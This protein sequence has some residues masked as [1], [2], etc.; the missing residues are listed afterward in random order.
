MIVDGAVQ[1]SG[2][3]RGT[4]LHEMELAGM[5]PA[6]F[7]L[8][9]GAAVRGSTVDVTIQ[10]TPVGERRADKDWRLVAALAARNARTVVARGENAGQ[11]LDA[12][13]VVRALSDR[14]AVP[15]PGSSTRI[16]LSKPA[17]LA[18]PD[19][20]L[21]VFAQ[22]EV[23]REIGA[24]RVLDPLSGGMV[25]VSPQATDVT[26]R[27]TTARSPELMLSSRDYSPAH[28]PHAAVG[29]R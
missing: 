11:I 14:V 19:V 24:V 17:D 4:A 18:W 2:Q 6:R 15:S 23:T 8:V 25:V 9:V 7:D 22:S 1:F 5:R 13:A 21:V 12:A 3:R 27:R 29:V 16:A 28:R 10:N 20:E 26:A